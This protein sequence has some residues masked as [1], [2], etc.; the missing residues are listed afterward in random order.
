VP[1]AFVGTEKVWP[2]GQ[3]VPRLAKVTIA[4]GEPVDPT[5]VA[6]H[7]GRKERVEALTAEIMGRIAAL[8]ATTKEAG[9]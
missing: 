8:V 9:R 6:P 2:R 5:T 3:R 7:A 1:V 4:Y